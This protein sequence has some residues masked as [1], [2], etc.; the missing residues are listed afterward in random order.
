MSYAFLPSYVGYT[1]GKVT[2]NNPKGSAY[3]DEERGLKKNCF[4][5][6]H[7]DHDLLSI[8]LSQPLYSFVNVSNSSQ[9]IL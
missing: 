8:Q 2:E 9:I 3:L 1:C 7:M 6:T 5:A 4:N